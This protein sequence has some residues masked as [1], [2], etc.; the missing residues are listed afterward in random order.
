[1][2]AFCNEKFIECHNTDNATGWK[3]FNVLYVQ[4]EWKNTKGKWGPEKRSWLGQF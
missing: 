2:K 1:M 3:R 4:L